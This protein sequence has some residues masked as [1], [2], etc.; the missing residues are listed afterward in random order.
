MSTDNWER[1]TLPMDADVELPIDCPD[2]DRSFD[3]IR[4][5]NTHY[6]N[7]HQPDQVTVYCERCGEEIVRPPKKAR[8][9]NFC[10]F[11]CQGLWNS[12]HNPDHNRNTARKGFSSKSMAGATRDQLTLALGNP[13][14]RWMA[15]KYKKDKEC[16]LCGES[17]ETLHVHHIIPILSGGTSAE[18]LLMV[19]CNPCHLKVESYT[20]HNIV[21]YTMVGSLPN[22]HPIKASSE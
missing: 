17:E 20:L 10:S 15:T 3:S 11:V 6:G 7:A 22:E 2:C 19:L 16:E 13:S 12:K 4:G 14:W 18:P 1:K 5:Y 9:N 8:G 21:E